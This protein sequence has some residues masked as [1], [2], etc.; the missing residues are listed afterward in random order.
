[1]RDGPTIIQQQDSGGSFE[2]APPLTQ[3][4]MS[5]VNKSAPQD[6]GRA[7]FDIK[8][9]FTMEK[10]IDD[11][12]SR[13]LNASVSSGGEENNNI[14][15]RNTSNNQPQQE[16]WF[17]DSTSD[18]DHWSSDNI[19]RNDNSRGNGE[20]DVV[21]ND[22][23]LPGFLQ[24]ERIE[25][26]ELR[27]GNNEPVQSGL[28]ERITHPSAD[29]TNQSSPT[30]GPNGDHLDFDPKGFVESKGFESKG[31]ESKGFES[32][33]FESNG[34]EGKGFESKG[35]TNSFTYNP[36]SE[37]F[38][39]PKPFSDSKGFL[40]P[41]MSSSDSKTES[42]VFRD[43]TG[44]LEKGRPIRTPVPQKERPKLHI[45]EAGGT[46]PE[47]ELIIQQHIANLGMGP[48][49]GRPPS[50]P[51]TSEYRRHHQNEANRYQNRNF[52][53][54][55]GYQTNN[56]NGGQNNSYG[57]QNGGQHFGQNGH[58]GQ[59]NGYKN[60]DRN[61][62]NFNDRQNYQAY[63]NHG[64]NNNN[65]GNR[66]ERHNNF[67]PAQLHS[68]PSRNRDHDNDRNGNN[69]RGGHRDARTNGPSIDQFETGFWNGQH[70]SSGEDRLRT[71]AGNGG[72]NQNRSNYSTNTYNNR[73]NNGSYNQYDK[74]PV[75]RQLSPTDNF[76]NGYNRGN[77][78]PMN[79]NYRQGPPKNSDGKDL[80]P[81]GSFESVNFGSRGGYRN[82]NGHGR[83]NY[84]NQGYSQ[85]GGGHNGGYN[86][87]QN[88][89]Q[90]GG[91]N[92]GH[93]GGNNGGHSGGNNGGHSGGHN[94]HTGGYG[95]HSG[96]YSGQTG[97]QTHGGRGGYGNGYN[98]HAQG[99]NGFG[100][101][102]QNQDRSNDYGH[103]Y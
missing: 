5:I 40:E 21:R 31:F 61:Y 36:M 44:F 87:G 73:N 4:I 9:P 26:S 43:P 65:F 10:E 59:V 70:E 16:S 55:G 49:D 85:N 92:G 13:I 37:S 102:R 2:S 27:S 84:N 35:F 77:N 25:R 71:P 12:I 72:Y 60:Q 96:N 86:V 88:G 51:N 22:N 52:Q 91:Q 42:K 64:D 103:R 6:N 89:G 94:G 98:N 30:R 53:N 34:F 23:I 8:L 15:Q 29:T 3:E 17:K 19:N 99:Q 39:D 56:G 74:P 83:G 20:R 46:T 93:A 79:D 7:R 63:N 80:F 45:T 50:P 11:Q 58:N 81:E 95:G 32:N 47:T 14:N 78:S 69:S 66:N 90:H 75:Q 48:K 41:K 38:A 1:M 68:T 100:Y 57:G 28:I 24:T 62:N 101:D 67:A 18:F 97:G 76:N 33:V 82:N 54:G